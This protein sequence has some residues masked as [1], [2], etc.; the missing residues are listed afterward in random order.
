MTKRTRKKDKAL[1]ENESLEEKI[2]ASLLVAALSSV[3]ILYL[4]PQFL[5]FTGLTTCPSSTL[6]FKFK[7][8]FSLVDS[9]QLDLSILTCF[10]KKKE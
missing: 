7:L 2:L 5:F 8:V 9:F 4:E 6:F 3:F 1:I 10:E